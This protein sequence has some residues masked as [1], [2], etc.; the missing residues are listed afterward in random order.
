MKQPLPTS[1]YFYGTGLIL[2][3]LL[4]FS[5]SLPMISEQDEELV[6]EGIKCE[7]P[8]CRDVEEPTVLFSHDPLYQN[9]NN[10]E[11]EVMGMYE[12]SQNTIILSEDADILDYEHE[13]RHACKDDKW[14]EYY[15]SWLTWESDMYP[16]MV[17]NT[18]P[19]V[20]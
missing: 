13:C 12:P 20:H 2:I 6:W 5:C 10:R 11:T 9:I 14:D 7:C 19:I 4:L 18:L 15:H 3:S 16:E 8:E 1:F 17:F